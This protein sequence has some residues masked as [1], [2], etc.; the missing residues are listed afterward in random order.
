MALRAGYFN[1]PTPCGVGPF[2]VDFFAGFDLYFNPPTPCG[3]GLQI[4]GYL[5][6]SMSFQST[7]PVRGG[8][9]CKDG[10][11]LSD[12]ISIH[13]PRA[14]WDNLLKLGHGL[15]IHFNPPTPCGVGPIRLITQK[16]TD[17]NFNPPTPC[18]VGQPG[19][20]PK[21]P[22]NSISIHPPRAGWD[23]HATVSPLTRCNF[24]PPTP[25]GVG[26][27]NLS[28]INPSITFQSTHPVRGGTIST[29]CPSFEPA[30]SI[31]PPRAGWDKIFS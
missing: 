24:N 4:F 7:H 11:M 30:I 18:G 21:N 5:V 3:V 31:H 26:H 17:N 28:H 23:S 13:P 22:V 15:G 20:N 29:T 8:T 1:P 12:D 10:D 2:S 25:C 16:I 6:T 27:A 14:G 19:K 9:S